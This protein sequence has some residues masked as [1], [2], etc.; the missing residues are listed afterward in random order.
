MTARQPSWPTLGRTL[1]KKQGYAIELQ[2][3]TEKDH[4]L[5][6]EQLTGKI[7][8]VAKESIRVSKL[9]AVVEGYNKV[10]WEEGRKSSR[11]S[12]EVK[13]FE[14][15]IL[16][17][18]FNKPIPVGRYFFKFSYVVPEFLPSSFS[19]DSCKRALK[20]EDIHMQEASVCYSMKAVLQKED[21][22]IGQEAVQPFLIHSTPEQTETRRK[23]DITEQIKTFG[24][25]P[26]G[27]ITVSVRLDKDC[28]RHDDILGLTIEVTNMTPLV[29]KSIIAVLFRKLKVLAN[30]SQRNIRT[31]EFMLEFEDVPSGERAVFKRDLDLSETDVLPTTNSRNIKCNY[32][33]AVRCE[34]PFAT[35]IDATL[36][37]T[38]I[39]EPNE[40]HHK[41]MPP[42]QLYRPWKN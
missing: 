18:T 36:P 28:Y 30:R 8:L 19:L 39:S 20:W 12:E 26:R 24:C 14:E 40:N 33:L 1:A 13:L 9:V 35:S 21:V 6:G 25:F 27:Y 31:K 29:C 38:M 7:Y 17:R 16:V 3:A 34:V 15:R 23:Q 32:V 22:S 10:T 5:P 42:D 4:Y 37:V 11:Y 2:L 41:N